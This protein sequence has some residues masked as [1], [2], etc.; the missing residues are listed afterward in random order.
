MVTN[1]IVVEATE[2]EQSVFY[3]KVYTHLALAVLAF[4]FVEYAL[5][6]VVPEQL[7]FMMVGQKY[8]WLLVLGIFWLASFLANKWT[9]AQSK[10]TQYFGLAVYILLEAMIFLPLIYIA[11]AQTGGAVVIYQAAMLTLALFAGLSGV[12][13]FSKRDFSF[14][15]SIIMIGGFVAIGLIVAGMIFGFNLGLWFSVG[16]VLL[17]A[18]SILYETNRLKFNYA[19]TQYVGASLQLFASVMLMFWYILRILMS[20]K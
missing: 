12:A 1:T 13:F 2:Q 18:A 17:A 6:A 9:L 14:L 5:L 20:R 15:R 16:M 4:I 11:V 7:I 10:T 19:T 3:R 8:S